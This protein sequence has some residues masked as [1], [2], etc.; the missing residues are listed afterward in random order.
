M[1]HLK[2]F[3]GLFN[4]T[5]DRCGK[6]TNTMSM[7]W[8][9]TD[10]C[11]MDCLEAEKDEPDYILAKEREAEE[12]RKGNYNY[13][14]IRNESLLESNINAVRLEIPYEVYAKDPKTGFLDPKNKISGKSKIIDYADR[15]IVVFDVNGV[16]V[17]F[18]LS[19][20]HGGKKDVT[21]GKWYP[22]F[23]IATDR[24][25][26]KLSSSDINNYYGVDLFKKISQSLDSK[27]GDIRNDS[28]IPKVNP[29]G[30]HVDFINKDLNPT[31]NG[32]PDTKIK[33]NQNLEN[34][35]K[36]LKV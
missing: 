24:W 36:K 31:E 2:K 13:G 6:K 1:K 25:F 8:L 28:S 27:I 17:P 16:H 18:Y 15:K 21:S 4:Q 32:N 26:N 19:S 9:N 12:V 33:F 23:G 5:C 29:F 35:K 20:G 22:F 34:F 10:E 14:G 7:S 3:E 11:C 30:A